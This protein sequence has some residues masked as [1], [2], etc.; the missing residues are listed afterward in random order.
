MNTAIRLLFAVSAAGVLLISS[1]CRS[2][3][4]EFAD[5]CEFPEGTEPVIC[6]KAAP[7]GYMVQANMVMENILQ[8]ERVSFLRLLMV[9]TGVHLLPFQSTVFI[10]HVLTVTGNLFW[11]LVITN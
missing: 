11:Y 5:M 6:R 1:S 9:L 10:G 2:Y 3:P 4:F 8:L 7:S